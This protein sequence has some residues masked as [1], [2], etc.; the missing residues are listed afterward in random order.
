MT[1]D[2]DELRKSFET[3]LTRKSRSVLAKSAFAMESLKESIE[4]RADS[5]ELPAVQEEH[6]AQRPIRQWF[7]KMTPVNQGRI[8]C[9]PDFTHLEGTDETEFHHITTMFVDIKNST[10]LA[11]RYPLYEVQHIKNSILRAASETVRAMD[12]HV[13]RFMGDALMGYFGGKSQSKESTAMAAVCCAAMLRT[14]MQQVVVPALNARQIDARDLGFRVGI[15]FGDDA[16]V[17]WSSYGFSEVNEV[18]AT[19][20]YVDASA[21]LQSMASKDC[22]MLGRNLLHFLD[23]PEVLTS[24][25]VENRDGESVPVPFLRPNY[26]LQDGSSLNYEIRELNYEKFAALLPLPTELKQQI[27][28]AITARDGV[29]FRAEILNQPNG[30]TYYPSMSSSLPKGLTI[31]FTLT[32]SPRS[33]DGLR[34]PVNGRLTKQN[35]GREAEN[36]IQ[37][38]PEVIEFT[39]RPTLDAFRNPRACVK[40]IERD[41]A[42]RGIHFVTAELVDANGRVVFK[43]SIGVH[44]R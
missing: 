23:L 2:I 20:F 11:L 6:A 17:L 9:H 22:A 4:D 24:Q 27:T 18:T 40:S 29:S 13:H 5:A 41:T 39:F 12:G 16:E 30:T 44:V 31:R 34:L 33:L 32:A 26:R 8:G 35:C 42:Y 10:R 36:S 43:D 14:L 37:T 21:K 15:D 19:S 28:P 3:L 38:K 7:G 1:R 25:K